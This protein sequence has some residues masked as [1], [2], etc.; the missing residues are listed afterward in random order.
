MLQKAKMSQRKIPAGGGRAPT[1][2]PGP[3]YHWL[4]QAR[5]TEATFKWPKANEAE[6]QGKL[7]ADK[8][9]TP[10]GSWRGPRLASRRGR[11]WGRGDKEAGL[12]GRESPTNTS[13]EQTCDTSHRLSFLIRS[14]N[15]TLPCPQNLHR[16]F[17]RE[18]GCGLCSIPNA[19]LQHI[20]SAT[21][22][23]PEPGL[24]NKARPRQA[25]P[26]PR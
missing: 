2:A 17:G 22:A 21:P 3:R 7:D 24:E 16:A 20:M 25:A 23:S 10:G 15:D 4:T 5:A 6:V 26:F 1:C 13:V 11:R 18:E 8:I 14:T 19:S 9:E 12:L